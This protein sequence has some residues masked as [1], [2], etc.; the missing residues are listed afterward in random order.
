[1]IVAF[2]IFIPTEEIT[3]DPVFKTVPAVKDGRA[4]VIDG[5]PGGGVL[6]RHHARPGVRAGPDGYALG[7]SRCLTAGIG[8]R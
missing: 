2:P 4:V 3:D 8:S 5:R 1:V 6:A 7:E